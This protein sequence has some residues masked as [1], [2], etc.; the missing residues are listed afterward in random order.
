MTGNAVRQAFE[1][2]R[3]RAEMS[4]FHFHERRLVSRNWSQPVR[5]CP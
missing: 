3:T 4:D 5:R 1:H 2:L